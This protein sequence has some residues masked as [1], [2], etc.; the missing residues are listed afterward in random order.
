MAFSA[1]SLS[2]F[3]LLVAISASALLCCA[4]A[5]DFSIVGYTPEHLTNTDKLLEL[6]ESWMSEHS[7]AYKSVE[8]KVHRFEVFRENLMH[9]DQRNNE[10]NSYWLGLNE[11]ADLTHE[12]FKGRYLGLAKPQFSR[13]RQPSAN[14]R[15]R[16]I[17]DLPK[18]VDW[19]KKGAVA[20]VKDQGQCGSCWAFSTVAAVEGINQITTGN[21]SSL[22]EQ[23]LIDC[24]TTFNSGCNGGLMDYAFQYIISTGGL[25][26]EDD[27]PYLMEEGI[28]QEQKE[29]VERVTI[30]G[31]EDVP[32]N[33]D[34]SL[35]KALAH[36]PVSVAIE[37]S[38]RD[39]QFYKGGVFNGKC[40]TDLDHGVAAVGYGSSKGSD[41]VIVKN[42]WGPRWGEKGFI[43]MKRNT[44]K[45]EGL[46]GI[47]K[48]AS[49]PTKT[50]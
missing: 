10:I 26:K 4:F 27:Y 20:P 11:F 28:C 23:E 49:Y 22:S 8:E 15:Y 19:R 25:H 29:D 21:L 1:P 45:P 14:F 5:R 18:S 44:G 41:Y 43:R 39:F 31:Y 46:C 40:G 48:M 37:A 50:K 38:G 35:V 2:K 33:D 3:S 12:E 42:S 16:D 17:T 47:N 13:K 32:E 6:F 36:Q 7:K 34:E 30:S 24:D 9:I